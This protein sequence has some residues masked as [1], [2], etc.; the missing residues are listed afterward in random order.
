MRII[1]AHMHLGTNP[2]TKQYRVEDLVRDLAAA[3]ACGA[4]CFA[5]PEDMYRTVDDAE[6]R[7]QMN[8]YVR[9]AANTPGLTVYP[10]YFVAMDCQLPDDLDMYAGIK[11]HRHCDEPRYDYDSGSC[12]EALLEIERRRL[13]MTLEE[14]LANTQ[15]IAESY[16]GIPLII[17]HMGILNGG[18]E[19]MDVFFDR[20]DIYFDTGPAGGENTILRFLDRIGPERLVM[21]SDYSGCPLPFTHTP[22]LERRKIES[23][24]LSANEQQLILGGNIE[25]IL[26]NTS[27]PAK[28]AA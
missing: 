3:G 10:F 16:P 1:D 6:T 7:R 5:F 14:E 15:H 27:K 28:P 8:G 13:P 21:G 17:P 4:V 26:H 2:K 23:L 22:E 12:R 18:P 24:G 20:P 11:W 19:Q 25:R 9:D